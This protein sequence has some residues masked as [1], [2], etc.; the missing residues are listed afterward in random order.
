MQTW[1]FLR[2]ERFYKSD[3]P[4]KNKGRTFD[5]YACPHCGYERWVPHLTIPQL[6]FCWNCR[7]QIKPLEGG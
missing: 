1:E 2:N 5:V 6:N 3:R 4:T 7:E